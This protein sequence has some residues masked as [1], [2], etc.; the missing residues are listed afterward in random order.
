MS[1]P[2][3]RQVNTVLEQFGA[4]VGLDVCMLDEEGGAQLALDD[5]Y[6]SLLLDPTAESLVFLSSIGRPEASAEIYGRL[7]DANLFW[8][9]ALGSTSLARE[10]AS[11]SIVLQRSVPVA[12]LDLERFEAALEGFVD[13]AERLR[14]TLVAGEGSVDAKA[15]GGPPPPNY[16]IRG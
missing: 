2:L 8:S 16:L 15:D 11:R 7:L 12:G 4:H 13:S 6:V 9:G 10:A 5:T 3:H 1:S 14:D